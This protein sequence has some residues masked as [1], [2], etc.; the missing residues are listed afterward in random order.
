LFDLGLRSNLHEL[1][2]DPCLSDICRRRRSAAPPAKNRRR[3]LRPFGCRMG[4][5]AAAL[6]ADRA[7]CARRWRLWHGLGRRR[8]CN[9]RGASPEA[10]DGL[11][12]AVKRWPTPTAEDGEGGPGHARTKQGSPN[13]RTAV[14]WP[15]PGA[16]DDHGPSARAEK[17]N[18]RCLPN[19]VKG[20]GKLNPEWVEMLMGAPPGW[21]DIGGPL[22]PARKPSMSRRARSKASPR[23]DDHD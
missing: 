3:G 14:A 6:R 17:Y 8:R 2:Y 9:R 20:S 23:I 7:R 5:T 1:S 4:A 22:P 10:G 21:T 16:R 12:T 15:T 13:L 18:G 11:E 19:A